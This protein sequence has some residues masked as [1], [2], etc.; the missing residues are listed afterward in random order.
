MEEAQAGFTGQPTTLDALFA[1]YDMR[2]AFTGESIAAHA[3]IDPLGVLLLLG[4]PPTGG[5]IQAS[6]AIPA[7]ADAIFAYERGHLAIGARGE[8]LVALDRIAPELLERLNP[9]GRLALPTDPAFR[10]SP[11]ALRAHREAF[12]A[13]LIDD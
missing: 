3:A 9:I 7:V 12:A 13:G 8:F 2:C 5:A 10:P 6:L 11:A 1:A 4:A